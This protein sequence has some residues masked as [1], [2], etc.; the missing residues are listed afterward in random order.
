MAKMIHTMIRVKDADQSI[1]F[2][3]DVFALTV[4]RRIDFSNFSLIYLGNGQTSFELEL[5]WN[6]DMQSEYIHGNGYGHLAFVVDEL[7]STFE[8]ALA[9]GYRPKAIKDFYNQDVLVAKFFFITD[10]D[11]YEIEVIEKSDVYR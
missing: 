5:T 6:H 8:Q 7:E 3:H 4:K 11:G 2:Y 1:R 9:L 10:P